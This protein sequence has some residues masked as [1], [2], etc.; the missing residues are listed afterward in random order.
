MKTAMALGICLMALIFSI[1]ECGISS[2]TR[3]IAISKKQT[4]S[5]S[6]DHIPTCAQRINQVLADSSIPDSVRDDACRDCRSE[7]EDFAECC[8]EKDDAKDLN[9]RLEKA[10]GSGAVVIGMSLFSIILAVLV[11]VTSAMD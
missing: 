7:L 6:R 11:A 9:K 1:A 3:T 5:S 10:C 2:T 8:L 4:L